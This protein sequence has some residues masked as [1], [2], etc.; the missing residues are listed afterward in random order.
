MRSPVLLGAI[1]LPAALLVTG[2]SKGVQTVGGAAGPV[3]AP[4]SVASSGAAPSGSTPGSSAPSSSAPSSSGPGSSTPGSSTPGGGAP[5]SSAPATLVLGPNGLGTLRFGMSQAQAKGTGLISA[6]GPIVEGQPAATTGCIVKATLKRAGKDH[7]SVYYSTGKGVVIIDAY[8][9]VAS[10][11]GIG[12]GGTAKA[13][14][15]AYPDYSNIDEGQTE[16]RG[17]ASVPGNSGAVYRIEIEKGK[18]TEFT[19][20]S[21]KQDCYE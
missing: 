10:P 11:Q 9:G 17:Y 2:C 5:S 21:R 1:V 14:L 12:P 20:Q 8:A 13:V 18:V 6:W 4:P 19:L 3:T 15:A 7:G 16:G